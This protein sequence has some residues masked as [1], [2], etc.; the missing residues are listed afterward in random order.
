MMDEIRMV[1][2]ALRIPTDLVDRL[3]NFI[4]KLRK[5]QR[6]IKVTRSDA[7]RLLLA[8]ALDDAERE[9]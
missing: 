6:G 2:T 5:K 8:R 4:A 1:Q 9:R 3:D 7:M